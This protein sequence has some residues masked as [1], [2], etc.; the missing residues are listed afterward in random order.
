MLESLKNIGRF[1]IARSSASISI[2][3]KFCERSRESGPKHDLVFLEV[4]VGG[5]AH[6]I[7]TGNKRHFPESPFAGIHILEAR[8]FIERVGD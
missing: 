3:A 5:R 1:S 7:V 8:Q 4:A 2:R 6:F